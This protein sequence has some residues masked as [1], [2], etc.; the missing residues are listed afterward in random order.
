[1]LRSITPN[2][3]SLPPRYQHPGYAF[4]HRYGSLQ[5]EADVLHYVDFLR[6]SAGLAA[7]PPT[8]L[9]RIYQHFGIP[10]PLRV[11]LDEQ[12]G[13]LL[14]SF[15][16]L[17]LIKQAD[18][19]AR[20]RFTEGH[21]LMELLFDAQADVAERLNLA[22]WDETRKEQLCDAGAAE[23]LMPRS[24]FQSQVK[25]LGVSLE[26]AKS[27]ATLYQTSLLATLRRMVELSIGEHALVVWHRALKPTERR[28]GKPAH[29][30]WRIWWRVLSP[31]WSSGF[32]PRDKSVE[33]DSLLAQATIQPQQGAIALD[34]GWGTWVGNLEAM[35]IQIGEKSCILSLLQ[36]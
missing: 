23:L 18:P 12:Q 25:S 29:P 22:Q 16:G 17:I 27:L 4:L 9:D 15:K 30:K 20:Q 32:I 14:D 26:T 33:D 13:I 10:T 2:V 36:R 35:P 7:Q 6:E 28:R 21:E 34:L 24:S 5:E 1:M 8:D 19:I 31:N 11:A 3:S